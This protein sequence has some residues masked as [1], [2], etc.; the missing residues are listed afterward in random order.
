MA[1][2]PDDTTAQR[3]QIR[4]RYQAARARAAAIPAETRDAEVRL[5]RE[6]A[7]QHRRNAA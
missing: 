4:E 5:V 3:Q 7:A 6:I 2:Q 1:E